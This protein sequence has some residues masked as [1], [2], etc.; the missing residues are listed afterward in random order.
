MYHGKIDRSDMLSADRLNSRTIFELLGQTYQHS[1]RKI[2]DSKLPK[3]FT[4]SLP[5]DVTLGRIINGDS[6]SYEVLRK[7]LMLLKLYNFY[8]KADNDDDDAVY[9]NLQDF[10]YA[11][12]NV[13]Y[14]C[15]FAL[16][17]E[18][19]PFDCLLLYC[20]NSYDPIGTLH[21]VNEH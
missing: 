5:N 15:G 21:Y 6:I 13:L 2:K 1:G 12:N 3:Q 17:Y 4:E 11:L 10:R 8:E 7:T 14:D 9:N 19:H 18:R 16:I 20:A